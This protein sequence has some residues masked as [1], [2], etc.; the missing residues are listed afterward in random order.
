MSRRF[1]RLIRR[2]E[3]RVASRVSSAGRRRFWSPPLTWT[4]LVAFE[5]DVVRET[6]L[7]ITASLEEL[8]RSIA[9]AADA[10]RIFIFGAQIAEL[11][12][13]PGIGRPFKRADLPD[14]A[15]VAAAAR[16]SRLASGWLSRGESGPDVLD[17][18]EERFGAPRKVALRAVE[19]AIDHGLLDCGVSPARA[20]LTRAGA[21]CLLEHPEA[22]RAFEGISG[23]LRGT[24]APAIIVPSSLLT[25]IPWSGPAADVGPAGVAGAELASIEVEKPEGG[26][27]C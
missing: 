1:G 20:F 17:V 15:V 3:R 2:Q 18:L 11:A 27:G 21:E 9:R 16:S 26:A 24:D 23:E 8:G 5:F 6:R 25:R 4:K 22:E 19:R 14:L 13:V 10:L 7:R 12:D